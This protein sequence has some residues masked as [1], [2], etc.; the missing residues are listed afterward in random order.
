MNDGPAP[1]KGLRVFEDSELDVPFFFGREASAT[2]S[3]RT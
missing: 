2:S 3:R 1:Y